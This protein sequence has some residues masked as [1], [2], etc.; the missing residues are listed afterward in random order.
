VSQ[1]FLFPGQGSQHVGMGRELA[2]AIPAARSVFEEADEALGFALSRL[3]WEGPDEELT[4]TRNAQPALLVHS[5][6]ALRAID[7]A[8]GPASLAAGHSLAEF[9]AHVASGTLAFR[10]AVLAVRRRG[11]LMSEA[12]RA[13]PGTMA[14]ILGMDDDAVRDVCAE[15]TEGVCVPANFNSPGQVVVSGDEVGV[16]EGSERAREAGARKVMPLHVSGAFHSPL[17]EPA[18]RAL[19]EHL[20]DVSFSDPEHPVVSNV[21]AQPVSEGSVAR[22]LLVRQLTAPVLWSDSIRVMVEA[23]V[24]RF[25]ELGPGTVLCGLN[26]RNARGLPCVSVGDLDGLRRLEEMLWS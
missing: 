13:R 3:M 26:K 19:D 25:L 12:G 14:A 4:D 17:M 21:T 2:E 6:A 15:V 22:E 20:A 5:I 24:D 23:G 11:E 8:V 18:Q 9:T 16:A 10:D 7:G 1:A